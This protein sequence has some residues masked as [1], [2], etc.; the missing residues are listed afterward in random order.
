[1]AAIVLATLIVARPAQAQTST[2]TT[3][4]PTVTTTTESFPPTSGDGATTL[5]PTTTTTDP[6]AGLPPD[7]IGPVVP[8]PSNLPPVQLNP[9]GAD[10]GGTVVNPGDATLPAGAVSTVPESGATPRGLASGLVA[11]RGAE[12]RLTNAIGALKNVQA[13]LTLAQAAVAVAQTNLDQASAALD[14]TSGPQKAAAKKAAA[15][16]GRVRRLA[17]AALATDTSGEQM[18]AIIASKD[19]SMARARVTTLES[20]GHQAARSA[21][22]WTKES[23]ALNDKTKAAATTKANAGQAVDEANNRVT[24]VQALLTAANN[25]VTEAQVAAGVGP[26]VVPGIP[27]RVLAAYVRAAQWEA[28]SDP[29]CHMA[30]WALAA[31][32]RVE[33]GN[34]SHSAVAADGDIVPRIVGIPLDGTNGTALIPDSDHGL[35]D[36]DTTYDRAVG[37]MQFIPGT[38]RT[39]GMDASGDKVADPNNIYDAAFAAS[40][41]LCAGAGG[42]RVDTQ[43]GLQAAAFSYNH[44]AAYVSAVW[45]GSAPYR[46]LADA[47]ATGN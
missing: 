37:P 10:G 34:A 45:N 9:G 32:G 47:A 25:E 5:P 33:S 17:A 36:G 1:V 44:S 8:P 31:I 21:T 23:D 4:E 46:A 6:N 26:Q 39:N 24:A 27:D 2:S 40:R 13:E 7:D 3:L 18:L 30:W 29:D 19:P 41:Y 35:L 11:G 20:I 28:R 12:R 16:R 22:Q 43:A 14:A 38:W 15:T 42:Q